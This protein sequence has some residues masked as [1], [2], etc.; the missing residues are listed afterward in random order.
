[1]ASRYFFVLLFCSLAA[2]ARAPDRALPGDSVGADG[3]VVLAPPRMSTS[4]S[5]GHDVPS[6][7]IRDRLFPP[8]LVMEHQAELDLTVAQRDTITKEVEKLQK[9][10][11]GMQWDMQKEKEKL[12]KS[13]DADHVDEAGAA[14]SAA[15]VM[16]FETKIKSAHLGMLV[17]V[18]N[19]LT[20]EQQRKLRVVRDQE[21]CAAAPASPPASASAK[22]A[23]KKPAPRP[24]ATGQD[25]F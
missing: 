20:P 19:A 11:L 18:K 15:R 25:V 6:D 22:P 1:M 10:M 21:R 9:D 16:E 4:P 5:V 3:S 14:A 13:L 12:V 24:Q 8:E 7:P 17:R 23:P 2:C